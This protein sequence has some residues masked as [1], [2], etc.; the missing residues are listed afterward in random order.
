MIVFED[1]Y[2]RREKMYRRSYYIDNTLLTQ[3][4]ELSKVYRVK[5]PELVN[6]GVETLVK[7][8]NIEIYKRTENEL[9]MKY[10]VLMRESILN[11][12]DNLSE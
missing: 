2:G 10:T 7:T 5:I 11:I 12:L 4:E 3:L 6:D 8:E 1:K 9:S